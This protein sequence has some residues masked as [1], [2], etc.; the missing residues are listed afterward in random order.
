MLFTRLPFFSLQHNAAIYWL[1]PC[2]YYAR[3]L[4]P[5]FCHEMPMRLDAALDTPLIF[6]IRFDAAIDA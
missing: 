2:H 6:Q 3:R 4:L 5:Y 1:L